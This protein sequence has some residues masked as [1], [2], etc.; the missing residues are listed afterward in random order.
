MYSW[1]VVVW[2]ASKLQ[3]V[4]LPILRQWKT[5][6]LSTWLMESV[7][8]NLVLWEASSRSWIQI[9]SSAFTILSSSTFATSIC[10]IMENDKGLYATMNRWRIRKQ[11]ASI[12][13]LRFHQEG[14]WFQQRHHGILREAAQEIYAADA[15]A[16]S[17]PVKR[18]EGCDSSTPIFS[19]YPCKQYSR[20]RKSD[21]NT[22]KMGKEDIENFPLRVFIFFL[23]EKDSFS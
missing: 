22:W 1:L 6:V 11:Q 10:T 8:L 13:S 21:E 2:D 14:S 17:P 18:T 4:T 7:T 16:W 19:P 5:T 3:S 12:C 20:K 15:K 9:C 23:K